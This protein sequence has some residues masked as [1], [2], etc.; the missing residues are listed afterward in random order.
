M[1]EPQCIDQL[2]ELLGKKKLQT[3]AF[4]QFVAVLFDINHVMIAMWKRWD[5]IKL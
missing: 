4:I 3:F 5:N 1:T 2:E